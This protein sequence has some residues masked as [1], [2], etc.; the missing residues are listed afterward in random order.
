M[1]E[2]KDINSWPEAAASMVFGA[3]GSAFVAFA[4]GILAGLV[5]LGYKWVAP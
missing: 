4:L 1:R 2:K 5:H 3:V